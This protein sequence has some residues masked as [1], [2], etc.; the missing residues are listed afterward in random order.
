M[1]R[2]VARLLSAGVMACLFFLTI[3]PVSGGEILNMDFAHATATGV[4]K[5]TVMVEN[6]SGG[7]LTL[8]LSNADA[9]ITQGPDGGNVL[10]VTSNKVASLWFEFPMAELSQGEG[11]RFRMQFHFSRQADLPAVFRLGMYHLDSAAPQAGDQGLF[12]VVSQ[13]NQTVNV[14]QTGALGGRFLV[15]GSGVTTSRDPLPGILLDDQPHS[16][17]MTVLPEQSEGGALSWVI[18][19]AFEDNAV[20]GSH[21]FEANK[22][23]S[24][25]SFNMGALVFS[26]NQVL[27]LKNIVVETVKENP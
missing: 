17:Q 23:F 15:S 24:I 19:Y 12:L 2:P 27:T 11:L 13:Q 10:T 9:A 16:V 4:D 21:M 25:R 1:P 22:D 7:G 26:G 20:T 5:N 3:S 6:A 18:N 8:H 14:A